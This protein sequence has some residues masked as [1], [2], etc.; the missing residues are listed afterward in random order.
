MVLID[1]ARYGFLEPVLRGHRIGVAASAMGEVR[2]WKDET[3][4]RHGIDL[5][6][7]VD[8]G[9]LEVV[10]ATA[11]EFTDM[12]AKATSRALGAGEIE[13]MALVAA[14]GD[15]FCTADHLAIRTM[16][17]LGL[18]DSHVALVDVLSA[19]DPPIAVPDDKYRTNTES[20]DA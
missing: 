2:Y 14:R 15:R 10:G 7:Y 4:C 6:P 16:K 11:D 18:G 19:L 12:L 17:K 8:A 1:A 20:I 13:S 9:L 5:R 3:G